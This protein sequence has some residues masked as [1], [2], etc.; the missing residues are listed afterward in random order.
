MIVQTAVETQNNVNV[1]DRMWA[2]L[3]SST[4]QPDF[5]QYND[6]MEKKKKV[7]S[8]E[9]KSPHLKSTNGTVVQESKGD[10]GFLGQSRLKTDEVLKQQEQK[11]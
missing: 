8:E 2:R 4:Q 10:G 7:M 11:S 3:L 5:L 6:A 9:R 1:T